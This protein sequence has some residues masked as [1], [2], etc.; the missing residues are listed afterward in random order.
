MNKFMKTLSCV[1]AIFFAVGA[2][3]SPIPAVT[4]SY[5]G[6]YDV[7]NAYGG[8]G[9]WLPG[10]Y[11]DNTWSITGGSAHYQN[12]ILNLSGTAVNNGASLDFSFQVFE[13]AHAG[14]PYCGTATCSNAT[15]TMKDNVVYFNMGVNAIQGTISGTAGTLLDGLS[16]DVVMRP[17]PQKPG[18][19][20]FGANYRDQEFGYSNWMQWSVTQDANTAGIGY[21]SAGNGD[22]NF[23][24]TGNDTPLVPLPAGLPLMLT[25]LVGVYAMK[26][27]KRA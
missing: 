12:Q 6:H 13:T 10:F 24:F 27:R 26:R 21:G 16:M 22:V 19:L 4:D 3:A 9:L 17:L 8:H 11:G 5:E 25:G 7:N 14:T 15:Q 20:G 23:T 2:E 1:A 18:Q